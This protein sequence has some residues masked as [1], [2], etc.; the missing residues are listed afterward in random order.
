MKK[1]LLISLYPQGFSNQLALWYLKAYLLKY[2]QKL[3]SINI[4]I[5]TFPLFQETEIIIKKIYSQKPDIIGFSC[6]LWNIE[7]ILKLSNLIKKSMPRVRVVLGGPEVSA[8]PKEVLKD[9]KSPDVVVKGEG[10]ETFKELIDLFIFGKGNIKDIKGVFYR[11]KARIIENN[12][13]PEIKYLDTIP[14]PYIEGVAKIDVDAEIPLETSRGCIYKCH[15]CYY[16]KGF[17]SMRYFSMDR[18]EKELKLILHKRVKVLYIMDSTFDADKGRAKHILRIIIKH[19]IKSHLH[20]ELKAELLDKDLVGLLYKAK[21]NFIEIGIQSTNKKTLELINRDFNPALF[22]KNISLLNKKKIYYQIQLI[23]GLPADNYSRLKKSIDWLFNLN[24][25]EIRIMRL[26]LLPGTYLRQNAKRFKIRYDP[27]PPYYSFKSNTYSFKD[28]KKTESLRMAMN[29]LYDRGLMRKSLYTMR[30][31]LKINPTLI[32][33][34]WISWVNERYEIIREYFEKGS[35]N[36]IDNFIILH[37]ISDSI[38]EFIRYMCNKYS[39][40]NAITRISSQVRYDRTV[41]LK[42]CGLDKTIKE[43]L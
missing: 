17:G 42:N 8:R 41:F 18:V 9:N 35:L 3:S 6:Y 12:P 11:S 28:L 19:N 23:D 10:E 14:S 34:E 38:Y 43:I 30:D 1:I 16:H 15:Y 27:K 33:E 24:P 25:A 5:L 40:P 4:S 31:E 20:V 29:I 7:T 26:N 32:F 36:K 37:K 2:I 22:K 39:Y 21:T 13:R